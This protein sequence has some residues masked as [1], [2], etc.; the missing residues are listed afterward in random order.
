M[1]R[2]SFLPWPRR[3]HRSET[4]RSPHG[5]SGEPPRGGAE[6]RAGSTWTTP[7]GAP[8]DFTTASREALTEA[9]TAAGP[10]QSTLCE[11]WNTEHLAAH[12]H[13]R[14]TSPLALGLAVKPLNGMLERR[15]IALGDEHGTAETYP[16]LVQRVARGP[17]GEERVV[18]R[19]RAAAPVRRAAQAANLLEFF[20]HAEDV[21]R[22]QDRWAPR[23]LSDDYADTLWNELSRRVRLLYAGEKTGV[24]LVRTPRVGRATDQDASVVARSGQPCMTV[25]GPVG[26]LIMHAFGRRDH[27]LVLVDGPDTPPS[28]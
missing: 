5:S 11:G 22:A 7:T 19:A 27:A 2:A 10:G 26:E 25:T 20:V 16:Q 15:T 24:R 12:L 6:D 18:T 23:K 8:H 4:D 13:L 17:A 21:R 9:L 1:T 3:Q 28:R 14:E